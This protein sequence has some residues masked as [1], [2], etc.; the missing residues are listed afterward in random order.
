[1]PHLEITI[2]KHGPTIVI[3]NIPA[4]LGADIFSEISQA[5]RDHINDALYR[6]Y[7]ITIKH[8]V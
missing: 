3:L 2:S 6:G 1:M 5:D 4:L 7:T 8:I